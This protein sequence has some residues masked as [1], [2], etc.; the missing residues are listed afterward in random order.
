MLDALILL[1]NNQPDA[2]KEQNPLAFLFTF[3]P[4]ILMAVLAYVLLFLPEKRRQKQHREWLEKS[5][6]KNDEVIT[7][8]GIIGIVANIKE[9]E[10]EVVL[11]I[12][13]SSNARLRVLKSTIV[14]IVSPKDGQEQK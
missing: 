9:K 5:L 12:D 4:L 3:L 10:D 7:S 8:A 11:K 13:D 6:K 2:G 1:A 14:R